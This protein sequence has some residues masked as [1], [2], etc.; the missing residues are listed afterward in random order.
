MTGCLS[1]LPGFDELHAVSLILERS[2]ELELLPSAFLALVRIDRWAHQGIGVN[3]VIHEDH[4]D[5]RAFVGS[6][7]DISAGDF[8]PCDTVN[9]KQQADERKPSLA[10]G[11]NTLPSDSFSEQSIP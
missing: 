7:R 1:S 9:G 4:I 3:E 6:G 5:G 2:R 8:H 10:G 11:A